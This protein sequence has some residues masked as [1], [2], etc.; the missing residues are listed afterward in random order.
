MISFMIKL[1]MLFM[2][3]PTG[4]NKI[5]GSHRFARETYLGLHFAMSSY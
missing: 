3:P 2:M 4:P 5:K 1:F